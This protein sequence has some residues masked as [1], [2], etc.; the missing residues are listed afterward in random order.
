MTRLNDK[1]QTW[2]AAYVLGSLSPADRREFETHL[3]GCPFCRQAVTEL[4]GMPALLTQLGPD[5][6]ASLDHPEVVVGGPDAEPPPGL[7]PALLTT[8][9]RR[10]RRAHLAWAATAAAAA[11]LAI[12]GF[13]GATGHLSAPPSAPQASVAA[14][15][16][17]PAGA[18][19]LPMEQV[20]TALLA[21][22]VSVRNESW[23]TLIE[24]S[25]VCLAPDDAPHDT[26]ALVVV[27]RDGSR[28][29]LASWVAH[30]GHTATPAG[31]TSLPADQIGSVQVVSA[32]SGEV[33]LQRTL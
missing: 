6:M 16:M 29:R 17:V 32:D 15:P 12:G 33:L 22:T 30:P 11:A 14:L 18:G 1:Y 9:R 7:L 23:G 26:L 8:V 31:S 5:V 13:A 19:T 27:G 4:N 10:R 3:G 28:S 2:D 20:H 25:C 21:S 24:L